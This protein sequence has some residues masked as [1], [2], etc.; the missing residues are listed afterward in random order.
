[1]EIAF[2]ISAGIAVIA[3]IILVLHRNPLISALFLLLVLLSTAVIFILLNAQLIAFF[4]MILYAGAIVVLF[5]I[6]INLIPLK[7]EV[8]NLIKISFLRILAV[9]LAGF[10]LYQLYDIG[11]TFRRV[12]LEGPLT[13][14]GV[15]LLS[16]AIF[17]RFVLQFEL[18]SVL[19]LA[20]IV[21]AIIIAKRR[22]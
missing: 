7:E 6:S 1:M 22:M 9:P 18:M 2:Y 14:G 17:K 10:L 12:T 13:V 19:L 3:S 11:R 4:Q 20:G 21:G 5:V 8:I 16:Q 15:D